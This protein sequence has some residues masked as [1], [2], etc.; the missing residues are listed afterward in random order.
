MKVDRNGDATVDIA[1]PMNDDLD[2]EYPVI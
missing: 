1:P 2:W